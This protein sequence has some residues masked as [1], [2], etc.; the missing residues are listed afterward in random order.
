MLLFILQIFAL[1]APVFTEVDESKYVQFSAE[2]PPQFSVTEKENAS[3]YFAPNLLK[4][5]VH[6][7]S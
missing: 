6:F 4:F 2:V 1:Q 3:E 7:H 5:K